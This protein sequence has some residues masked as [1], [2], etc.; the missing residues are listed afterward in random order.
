MAQATIQRGPVSGTAVDRPSGRKV[1][2]FVGFYRSAVGKKYVMAIT[3]IVGMFYGI[4]HMLGNMK[5]FLG[6][7]EINHYSEFLRELLVPIA[8]RSLVLWLL[9]TGLIVALILHL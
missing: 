6:A 2:F 8:P 7:A 3:G 4:A 1:P 5:M 9:R